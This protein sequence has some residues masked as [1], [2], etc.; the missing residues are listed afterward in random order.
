[1]GAFYG[2]KIVHE[3]INVRTGNPWTMEDVPK[4]WKETTQKWIEEHTNDLE[5]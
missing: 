5:S 4:R 2:Y 1:M 3:E